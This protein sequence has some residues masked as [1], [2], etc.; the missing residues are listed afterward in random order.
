MSH[1]EYGKKLLSELHCV[2]PLTTM[3]EHIHHGDTNTYEHCL[4]VV[5]MSLRFADLLPI[6]IDT[7]ALVHGAML[8]DFFGY[9]WR[10][11]KKDKLGNHGLEHPFTSVKRASRY[12]ELC[13]KSQNII[14]AH[15]WPENLFVLPK[16]TEAWIV[17]I[18]DKICAIKE[19]F[20]LVKNLKAKQ[21]EFND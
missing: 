4:Y 15:M 21:I 7:K 5:S 12:I 2:V 17:C 3:Q 6:K 20:G 1:Q 9:D 14:E 16:S 8:H 13:Q 11:Y 10:Q 18:T 19:T